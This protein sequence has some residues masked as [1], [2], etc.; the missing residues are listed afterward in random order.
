MGGSYV[1]RFTTT[2][3]SII[4]II[5][6]LWNFEREKYLTAHQCQFKKPSRHC[7]VFFFFW[8]DSCCTLMMFWKKRYCEHH[9]QAS[10]YLPYMYVSL[11]ATYHVGTCRNNLLWY[12]NHVATDPNESC[13]IADTGNSAPWA[14]AGSAVRPPPTPSYCSPSRALGPPVCQSVSGTLL[15]FIA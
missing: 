10:E 14:H 13:I 4:Y 7:W 9:V 8:N 2:H 6:I 11:L 5:H 15:H 3:D 12:N 1:F